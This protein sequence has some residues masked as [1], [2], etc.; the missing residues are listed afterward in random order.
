MEIYDTVFKAGTKFRKDPMV[1]GEFTQ[2]GHPALFSISY[3]SVQIK[4]VRCKSLTHIK[5]SNRALKTTTFDGT[6]IH[7]ITHCA[8]RKLDASPS[9]TVVRHYA[10]ST[11]CT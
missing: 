4:V 7:K 1:Y 6:P 3:E 8:S 5:R 11:S 10:E 9:W 2:G